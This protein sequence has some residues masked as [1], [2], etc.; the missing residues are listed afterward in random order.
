MTTLHHLSRLALGL[1]AAFTLNLPAVSGN[2]TPLTYTPDEIHLAADPARPGG[3]SLA[4][5]A[6]G[7]DQPGL[8]AVRIRLPSQIRV[9]PHVHPDDRMVV[10]MA[11][12]VLIGFGDRFDPAQM[13]PMPPG[14]FFVE[15]A[16][17][18]HFAWVPG[19][20]A[21]VQVSGIGPSATTYLNPGPAH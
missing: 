13:R 15:P 16:N 4:S 7:L 18:P 10:V 2:F 14:S 17:T 19:P 8:Y 11:G 12:T 9:Q 20:D 5:L 21:I 6:G 1:A 3:M